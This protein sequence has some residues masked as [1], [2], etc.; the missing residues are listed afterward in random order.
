MIIYDNAS[1]SLT[2]DLLKVRISNSQCLG[3]IK[4]ITLKIRFLVESFYHLYQCL[5]LSYQRKTQMENKFLSILWISK[6]VTFVRNLFLN[7]HFYDPSAQLK[8]KQLS[9][10]YI[11]VFP[12]SRPTMIYL[13][14]R[15]SFVWVSFPLTLRFYY[16]LAQISSSYE[17]HVWLDRKVDHKSGVALLLPK[18]W[19]DYCMLTYKS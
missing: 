12:G 13:I 1:L 18:H 6:K 10:L 2:P 11:L 7:Q 15:L 3:L 9:K 8:K 4:Y 17:S 19:I 16:L 14:G 5:L